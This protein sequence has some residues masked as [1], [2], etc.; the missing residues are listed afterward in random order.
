MEGGEVG[1]VYTFLACGH[2]LCG[3]SLV[4]TCHSR[5]TLASHAH[6]IARIH[7]PWHSLKFMTFIHASRHQAEFIEVRGGAGRAPA[8]AGTPWIVF[9]QP[10]ACGR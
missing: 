5:I 6:P 3:V 4:G 10:Q 7:T 2:G 1:G 8:A 9:M